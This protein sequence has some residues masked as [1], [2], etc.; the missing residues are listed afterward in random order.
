[1]H[2]EYSSLS[3]TCHS[4]R[5][6]HCV[7]VCVCVLSSRVEMGE[8][9]AHPMNFSSSLLSSPS[10]LLIKLLVSDAQS[11]LSNATTRAPS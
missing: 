2:V 5:P 9:C 3:A 4:P 11:S 6:T 1:M 7:C 8:V 10:L